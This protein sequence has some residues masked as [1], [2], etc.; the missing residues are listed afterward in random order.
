VNC[1][2][3]REVYI[4][5]DSSTIKRIGLLQYFEVLDKNVNPS[6]AKSKA[7]L[8]LKLY[9]RELESL[10]LECLGD[11]SIRAGCSFYGRIE[12][13][14][15]DKR[16]IVRSVTHEFLPVHTMGLEVAI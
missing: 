3:K 10:S 2:G 15:L 12:D 1:T 9:N 13:I 16:L 14:K 5:K 4:A 11:T 8:L 6:Q 7:D